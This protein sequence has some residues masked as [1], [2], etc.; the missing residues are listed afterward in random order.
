M[1]TNKDIKTL[2]EEILHYLCDDFEGNQAIVD[3]KGR[4]AIFNEI[5]LEMIMEKVE[6]ALNICKDKIGGRR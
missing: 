1:M 3:R 6:K 5:D 2:K 4:Y